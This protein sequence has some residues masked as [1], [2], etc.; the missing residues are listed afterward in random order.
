MATIEL[1]NLEVVKVQKITTQQDKEESVNHK[2]TIKNLKDFADVSIT[3]TSEDP[4][5]LIDGQDI[6]IILKQ[7]QTKLTKPGGN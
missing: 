2:V 6:D 4:L 7:K 1:N 3:I 5:D